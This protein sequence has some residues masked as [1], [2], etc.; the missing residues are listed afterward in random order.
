MEKKNK[1][2]P[3]R[4]CDSQGIHN[5]SEKGK[6][7]MAFCAVHEHG[8]QLHVETQRRRNRRWC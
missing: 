3:T 6:D 7:K 4:F 2:K 5:G 8:D 1:R